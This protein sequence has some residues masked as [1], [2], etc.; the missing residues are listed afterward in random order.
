MRC[1]RQEVNE[2]SPGVR[3]TSRFLSRLSAASS[4]YSYVASKRLDRPTVTSPGSSEKSAGSQ[5]AWWS[6][7][8]RRHG[9]GGEEEAGTQ[10][11][12]PLWLFF[13]HSFSPSPEREEKHLS[14][15]IH[16]HGGDP[17]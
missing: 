10:E 9:A 8:G 5:A 16:G 3:T 14:A 12:G 11:V 6:P 4:L 15:H 7:V 17:G 2:N 13:P 1:S